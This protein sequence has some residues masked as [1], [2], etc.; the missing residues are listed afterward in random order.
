MLSY[1]LEVSICWL[2]FYTI[3]KVFLTK[4]T[5]FKINRGYLL[6]T[7]LL[8]MLL[9]LSRYLAL[10][11]MQPNEVFTVYIEP[12]SIGLKGVQEFPQNGAPSFL[13]ILGVIYF[14]GLSFFTFRF[15][16]GLFQI[17]QLYN[18]ATKIKKGNLV[19]L[20]TNKFHMPF[21]FF[22]CLFWSNEYNISEKERAKIIAHEQAHIKG[23]HSIDVIFLE[24]VAILFWCSPIV[25]FYKKSL[26]ATHEFLADAFVLK[27]NVKKDYKQLLLEQSMGG[28]QLALTNQFFNSQL[29]GRIKMINKKRSSKWASIKYLAI[30]PAVIAL[31][32]IF[33]FQIADSNE[34]EIKDIETS[35]LKED[36]KHPLATSTQLLQDDPI[37]K[38]VDEM[39]RFPGCEEIANKEERL[40]CSR[41]KMLT[42]IYT[43]VKY[44]EEARLQGIEGQTVVQF[45]VEKNGTVSNLKLLRDIGGNCGTESL[46][47]VNAMN[48]QN[49]KWIP[50]KNKGEIVRVTFT[51]PIRFKLSP[52]KSEDDLNKTNPI[53][54]VDG[55]EITKANME[56][57]DPSTIESMTVTKGDDAINRLGKRGKHGII[58]ITLKNPN[59][60][61]TPPP[62]P[63]PPPPA[64][65]VVEQ[66]PRFP[67]CEDLATKE[68]KTECARDKMLQFIYKNIKYPTE[69][70][71]KGIE[72]M[73]VVQF[74]VQNDGSIIDAKML[75]SI[76]GGTD[77]TCL[78]VV[79][80]MNHMDEKWTPGRQRGR[81]VD[82]LFTLPIRFK[83]DTNSETVKD[84]KPTVIAADPRAEGVLL[85]QNEPNPF[86]N[87]TLISFN[88][89]EAGKATIKIYNVEGQT[90]KMYKGDY[91]KGYNEIIISRSEIKGSGVLYY[92]LE[93]NNKTQT[94]KMIIVE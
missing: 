54:F 81:T 41:D 22:N 35:F 25:Y 1:I 77:K 48:D 11:W 72:G 27:A 60:S 58:D 63:P 16:F 14:L 18:G 59:N 26:K 66:M 82:V 79:E 7:L 6:T 4:E 51:M 34:N 94:K 55:I 45:V 67:G 44:P 76:G 50:G 71:K 9:P 36:R 83:L 86:T 68:E 37:F 47:A 74:I 85:Y 28:M 10:E 56:A 73:N 21:S 39:P 65:K 78:D 64:Y 19:L 31:L 89:L 46:A 53:I 20:E 49:I 70:R 87:E 15:L 23:H 93:A 42:F 8:G 38:K 13:N 90:L 61:S 33:A 2:V 29:K 43:N 24:L 88:L 3:Y 92:T 80:M 5:F 62:P 32:G 57:I 40:K 52:D 69:A 75:R 91:Q 84:D 17:G 12:I 30:L